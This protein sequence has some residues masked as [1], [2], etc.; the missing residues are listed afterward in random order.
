MF[1]KHRLITVVAK[2]YES[3]I[4]FDR[5]YEQFDDSQPNNIGRPRFC[6]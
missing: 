4:L 6:I 3:S 1:N 2:C 5:F